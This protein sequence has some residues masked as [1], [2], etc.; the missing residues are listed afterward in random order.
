MLAVGKP[1]S[2]PRWSPLTTVALDH[3]GGA[4]A[5]AR[6]LHVAGR[7]Q[8]PDPGRGDGLA[9]DLDQRHDPGLELRV[10]FQHRR[11]AFGFG[12]EAEVL[13][14]RDLLG[15]ELLE[16]DVL[17][18]VLGAALGELLVEGDD[19]QLLDPEAVDHV[20]LDREGHD[21]LRQRRRVQDLERV[22]VEGEDGVGALDHRLVA[23]VDA[24]EGADRDV[25]R[26]AAR[27]RAAR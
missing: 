3:E 22:R 24:V 25:A 8:G 1:S 7:D 5:A 14:D 26:A 21:Q 10:R 13:A 20:A 9:V 23:E 2:R 15:A 16:Q 6:A 19:D 27:R 12:A 4:E 18:E 17:D 11:V